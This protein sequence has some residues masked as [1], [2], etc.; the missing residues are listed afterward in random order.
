[1]ALLGKIRK[2]PWL[3]I[4]GIGLPLFAFLVGDAF[5]QGNV[6]GNPNELGSING[7]PINIQDYNLAYNRLAKDPRLEGAS[8]NLVSQQAWNQLLQERII[9]SET[10]ELGLNFTDNQYY[11][12]AGRFFSSVNPDLVNQ[13]NQVNIGL[14]KQF[15]AQLQAAAQGGNP[16]A[17]YFFEQW[18]NF[19]PQF[20][21]LRSEF[22]SLV[23]GGILPTNSEVKFNS[24][25]KSVQSD[26]NYVFV[27]YTD[28]AKANGIT[29]SD[30]EVKSYLKK[31]KKQFKKEPSVNLSY[32]YFPA[33]ASDADRQKFNSS[34]NAF[35]SSQVIKDEETGITD[36]IPSFTA[37][38][39]DSAYVSRYSEAPF[40]PNYY[41]KTQLEN[42]PN[43]AIKSALLSN[44]EKG[45][46]VGP[47]Q[48]ENLSQL[49]KISDVKPVTDSVKSSHILIGFQGSQG[50]N[51]SLTNEQ[52]KAKADS[53]LSVV[54]E[55]PAKFN[56]L[57]SSASD[58]QVAA[59][60]NGSV[61]W[62]SRFQQNFSP[63]Y[64]NYITNNPKGS[65]D[66]VPSEFG[67]HIIRIDDV[68][69]KTGYQLA[70][71]Q[72]QLMPSEETQQNIFNQSSKVAVESQGKSAN[73]FVNSARSAGAEVSTEY[74]LSRFQPQL[75]GIENTKKESDILSWAFNKDTKPGSIQRFET[76]DGGQIVAYLNDK[77]SG[78]EYNITAYKEIV[79]PFILHEKVT[80][81][82][83]EKV[84]SPKDLNS[85]AKT[86]NTKVE[87]ANG[88]TYFNGNLPGIGVEQNVAA[89]AF[90]L[91]KGKVSSAIK[92]N[93]GVFFIQ[94]SN[95][96]APPEKI[97]NEEMERN[98]IQ[99]QNSTLVQQQLIP[100]FIDASDL[101]DKRA[102]KL[103]N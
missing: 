71:I 43:E 25:L 95:K 59:K 29:V 100:S 15:L 4:L 72:K 54:K 14:A 33:Q 3:L 73:D 52:A 92:G 49:I 8:Q 70:R 5:S 17:N 90:G 85:I 102:E 56:E 99:A 46:V 80:K 9:S 22:I 18:Q 27:D 32:A 93:N 21:A 6:F 12:M 51:S 89:A 38:I 103:A 41:T 40:D 13:N 16:Q 20:N 23:A 57:A 84:G 96:T 39:N 91:P 79:E 94:P 28:Y 74:G 66:L 63:A 34:I 58:D 48:V 76:N 26:I 19:N 67:Y 1:M 11:Q 62:V 31:Y 81:S 75:P 77:F 97:M 47:I 64:L 88:L 83:Q 69:Q 50:G 42:I 78:D 10:K 98:S 87:T 68:K 101:K 60:D 7:K 30:D 45:K 53:L 82:I 2:N 65:I 86:L 55:N 24:D 35:L 44:L 36:S 61:G 37:S